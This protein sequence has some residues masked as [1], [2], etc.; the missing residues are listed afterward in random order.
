MFLAVYTKLELTLIPGGLF[1]KFMKSS[2]VTIFGVLSLFVLSG[3]GDDDK[4]S[5]DNPGGGGSIGPNL[6]S[7]KA[8]TGCTQMEKNLLDWGSWQTGNPSQLGNDPTRAGTN[9]LQINIDETDQDALATLNEKIGELDQSKAAGQTLCKWETSSG[10]AYIC[11]PTSSSDLTQIKN[12]FASYYSS[13]S[14]NRVCNSQQTSAI[15]GYMRAI[16]SP[17]CTTMTERPARGENVEV[18][19]TNE[20][21]LEHINTA[22]SANEALCS[23]YIGVSNVYTQFLCRT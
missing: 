7:A 18:T 13:P 20:K 9:C 6:V 10:D 23:W 11:K 22:R 2:L 14:N 16:S 1:M 12:D 4:S 15:G 8:A 17:K 19:I 5:Q 21:F 3:C